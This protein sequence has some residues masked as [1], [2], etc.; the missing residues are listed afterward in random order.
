MQQL[1][2]SV[3]SEEITI[4]TNQNYS[5][6]VHVH[7]RQLLTVLIVNFQVYLLLMVVHLNTLNQYSQLFTEDV[8][9]VFWQNYLDF[10]SHQVLKQGLVLVQ[11]YRRQNIMSR[12]HLLHLMEKL[13]FIRA[14]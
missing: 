13:E 3:H 10:V 2:A 4:S 9:M 14:I 6:A 1:L 7:L 12:E 8:T 11:R 5:F